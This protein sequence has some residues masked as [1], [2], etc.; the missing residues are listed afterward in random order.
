MIKG[1][2]Y[3]A[4]GIDQWR[5]YEYDKSGNMIKEVTFHP[6]GRIWAW[7][8]YE[9]NKSGN[10]IRYSRT[11]TVRWVQLSELVVPNE[12]EPEPTSEPEPEPT[13][14]PEPEMPAYVIIGNPDVDEYWGYDTDLDGYIDVWANPMP[15]DIDADGDID[16]YWDSDGYFYRTLVS[17]DIDGDGVVDGFRLTD[18]D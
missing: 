17:V 14:E 16:G 4:D 2:R 6:D 7:E 8:E 11:A 10:V 1:T 3:N 9:Y 18:R 15:A 5:E 13:S 12:P